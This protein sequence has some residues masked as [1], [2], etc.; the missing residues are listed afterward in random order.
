MDVLNRVAGRKD[1]IVNLNMRFLRNGVPTEPYAVRRIDIYRGSIRGGNMVAQLLFN[2]PDDPSYPFPAVRDTGDLSEFQVLFAVPSDFVANDVYFDVWHFLGDDP[3]T[4]GID[5][6]TLWMSQYGRFWVYEDVWLGDDQLSSKRLG[7][8]PL[9]KKL[10]RG[11]VRTI[12]VALHTLPKY[13]YSYN[14]LAPIIP[15]LNPTM[16]VWTVHDE[17]IDG[18]VD[19]PC[20]IGVRQGH[21][22]SSPFVV[23]CLI[24]TRL[25]VRGMYRYVIKVQI[26]DEIIISPKFSFVVA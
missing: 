18:L 8:E 25:L 12:E 1:N 19:A 13:D 6:E 7:F 20:K 2:P 22:R 23:Q 17:L 5:D 24:D 14:K 10:R 15:Q 4:S 9:D 26:Y 21:Q 3:Q 16:T 11:E